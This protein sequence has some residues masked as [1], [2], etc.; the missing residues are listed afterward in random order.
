MSVTNVKVERDESAW[1]A[2]VSA[3]ISADSLLKYREEA[4]R[5]MQKSAKVDGFRPGKAPIERILEIYGEASCDATR[6]RA[7]DSA[8]AS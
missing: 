4:L 1:E 7:C 8:R 5:E 2:S 6:C 3:E